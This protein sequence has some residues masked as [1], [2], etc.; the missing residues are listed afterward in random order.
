MSIWMSFTR[1]L[2]LISTGRLGGLQ[3]AQLVEPQALQ[4]PADGGGGDTSFAGD[5]LAGHALAAQHLDLVDRGLGRRLTQV[6]GT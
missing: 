2:A 4:H 1:P 6:F 3:G 5:R